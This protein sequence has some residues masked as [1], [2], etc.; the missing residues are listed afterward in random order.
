[1]DESNFPDLSSNGGVSRAV[2]QVVINKDAAEL[3]ARYARILQR[4]FE[5]NRDALHLPVALVVNKADLLLGSDQLASR[6]TRR[7][8][9]QSKRRWNWSTRDYRRRADATDPFARLRSCIHYNLAISRNSQ[10]QRFVFELIE[11]FKDFIAAAMCHT[12][13]FQIFLTSSLSPKNENRQSLPYGVWDV[14]KWMFNQLDP[15]Y[16]L[17]ADASIERACKRIRGGENR[18]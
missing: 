3:A 12:Y 9:Y 16:R 5:V 13:R 2:R 15:A 18:F 1:M 10:I 6:S 8:S 11:Q 14:M 7:F 17:Q 4:Y